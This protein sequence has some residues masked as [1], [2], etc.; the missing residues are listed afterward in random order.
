MREDG[1]YLDYI[2]ESIELVEEY[3]NR[4]GYAASRELFYND[5]LVQDGVLRRMETLADAA[6]HL[7]DALRARHPKIPWHKVTSFRNVL[8]H[9]YIDTDLDLVWDTISVD[10]PVLKEVV[11][12][13]LARAGY[14]P[15]E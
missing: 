12:E 2:G 8:A 6:G 4:A 1:P 13:E 7:S 10:L 5:Q 3:L 15:E 11:R 9:G 14:P